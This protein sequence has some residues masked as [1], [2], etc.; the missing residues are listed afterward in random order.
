MAWEW[1]ELDTV[2]SLHSV[3]VSRSGGMDGLRDRGLL[4][5]ALGRPRHLAAYGEPDLHALAAA[6]AF[7]IC[8]NH[9]FVDGNKRAALAVCGVFLSLHGATL[10][11]PMAE[12]TDTFL[13]LGAGTLDEAALAEWLRRHAQ[14]A[15]GNAA[16]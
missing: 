9:P 14:L 12:T 11:A 2:L 13:A 4:E 16:P 5:S 1:L 8:R 7:G 10:D 15:P 3:V 6:Y